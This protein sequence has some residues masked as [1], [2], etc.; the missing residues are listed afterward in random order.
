LTA[1]LSAVKPSRVAVGICT[2]NRPDLLRQ[3][4]TSLASQVIPEGVD[5][6]L[7]VSDNEPEP[8]NKE[9]VEEFAAVSPFPVEYV[10]EPRR[11][12]SRARNALLD[13]CK[14]RFDWI[15]FTDD[16]CLP[17]PAWVAEMLAAAKRHGADVVRGRHVWV[18]PETGAFWYMPQDAPRYAEGQRLEHAGGGNV[19]F[20]G[21]L[22]RQRFDEALAH[23]EDT[24]FF[25]RAALQGARIVYSAEPVI[26]ETVPPH[27]ATLRYQTTR[28]FY[29]AASR[30]H[31]HRR[32]KGI[33]A[34]ALKVLARLVWQVPISVIRLVTAPVV[35]PFSER[36]FKSHVVKG[37]RRLAAAAGAM[38]GL[39]GWSGNPYGGA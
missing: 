3:C 7:I 27:R 29:Y 5:L 15:A 2:A 25:H 33:D 31:F 36:L 39:C 38:V 16:D 1:A 12:I 28:S 30:S 22:T 10:H 35:W 8:N 11:G 6:T 26:Y 14:D 17:T 23:G 32:Y 13:A 20:A 34:A 9:A 19:L 37:L 4:L 24:D 21:W 18:P